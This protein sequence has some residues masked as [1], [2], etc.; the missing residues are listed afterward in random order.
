[1]KVVIIFLLLPILYFG[2][3][4]YQDATRS[5]VSVKDLGN[6]SLV[7][8]N[9]ELF[10]TGDV[11]LTN[12]ERVS[13]VGAIQQNDTLY[14]YVMKTKS[15]KKESYLNENI[16]RLMISDRSTEAEEILLVS[17][18]EIVVEDKKTPNASYIDVTRYSDKKVL[19]DK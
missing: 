5:I 1:M 19:S 7:E 11:N 12:F 3:K 18:G 6:I 2:W 4:F 9:G 17:G 14:I 16:T 10:L 8:K 13:N 15:L